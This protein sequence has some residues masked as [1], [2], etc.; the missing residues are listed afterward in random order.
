MF[1][2]FL[3]FFLFTPNFIAHFLDTPFSVKGVVNVRV[4]KDTLYNVRVEKN[5][6]EIFSWEGAYSRRQTSMF[7]RNLNK[8]IILQVTFRVVVWHPLQ[9]INKSN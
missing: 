1:D 9:K 2:Y 4:Q 3:Y 6:N 5:T 7:Y 8:G